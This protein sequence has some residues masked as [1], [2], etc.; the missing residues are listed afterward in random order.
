MEIEPGFY[1]MGQSS[2]DSDKVVF[3]LKAGFGIKVPRPSDCLYFIKTVK[4]NKAGEVRKKLK[5]SGYVDW[6]VKYYP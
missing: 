3:L 1:K 5:E 2:K 4:S 6:A